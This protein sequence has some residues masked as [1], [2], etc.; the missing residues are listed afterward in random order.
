ML[1]FLRNHSDKANGREEVLIDIPYGKTYLS[2]PQ[3]TLS[4]PKQKGGSCWYYSFNYLRPRYGKEFDLVKHPQRR[5]EKI[6]SKYRKINT[7]REEEEKIFQAMKLCFPHKKITVQHLAFVQS[8]VLFRSGLF[9]EKMQ[10]L[11]LDF[12][13][14]HQHLD[15]ESYFIETNLKIKIENS[16]LTLS[17][18]GVNPDEAL[19][20]A[21][22][23]KGISEY[24]SLEELSTIYYNLIKAE[25]IKAYKLHYSLWNP[26]DD[27]GSL[28]QALRQNGQ[29]WV[30]GYFGKPFY[31]KPAHLLQDHFANKKIYGW[32][33]EDYSSGIPVDGAHAIV[34][35][36]AQKFKEREYVYYI[37]PNDPNDA[38][39]GPIIYKMSYNR[40]KSKIKGV[41]DTAIAHDGRSLLP[42]LKG[43]FGV[44]ANQNDPDANYLELSIN[45]ADK[46]ILM[47]K[48]EA[49]PTLSKAFDNLPKEWLLE[50]Q[51][52]T[53]AEIK[54]YNTIYEKLITLGIPATTKVMTIESILQQL[55]QIDCDYQD[56]LCDAT[57]WNAL[58]RSS[59]Q[60]VHLTIIKDLCRLR[61][62]YIKNLKANEFDEEYQLA[63][64]NFYQ[65]AVTIRLSEQTAKNQINA[66]MDSVQKNFQT[67]NT[68]RKMCTNVIL[69]LSGMAIFVGL[70]RMCMNKTFF[71]S[72]EPKKIVC[73]FQH[74]I[75]EDS[76]SLFNALKRQEC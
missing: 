53:F 70:V 2:N 35:I 15:F 34:V 33:P 16:R 26:K 74:L 1:K 51:K 44:H 11:F 21:L 67:K 22:T 19:R 66:M 6:I 12:T 69:L 8:D 49:Y 54:K 72:T 39:D 48:V 56:F 55:A 68:S 75:S 14:Q 32:N 9:S 64:T 57:F 65:E 29:F 63:L 17:R 61:E 23:T 52:Q 3:Q 40:F 58:V 45:F 42:C 30:A 25:A 46:K 76:D 5:I 7:E 4:Q 36:G 38:V 20:D 59:K 50:S 28:F 47:E 37:D 31:T 60:P 62:F 10:S 13:K 27:I 73:D 43:P 18:L 41:F 71:I 24:G